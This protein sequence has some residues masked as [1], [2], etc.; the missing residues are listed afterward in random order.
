MKIANDCTRCLARN[1]GAFATYC[2]HTAFSQTHPGDGRLI[3]CYP[4]TPR[5]CP[6]MVRELA[7]EEPLRRVPGRRKAR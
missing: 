7:R 5:W 4:Q 2:F 6:G 1:D 3:T